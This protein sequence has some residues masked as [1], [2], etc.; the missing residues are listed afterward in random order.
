MLSEF[1]LIRKIRKKIGGEQIGDDC[2]AVNGRPGYY[3]L[4]TA[5]AFVEGVH[6]KFSTISATKAGQKCAG[7]ALSDIAAMGGIPLY[8]LVSLGLPFSFSE[9]KV[10]QFYDGL[11]S[12]CRRHQAKIVGGNVTRS[13]RFWADVTVV[14]EVK[15]GECKFRSGARPGDDIYVTGSLGGAALSGYRKIPMPRI[16]EGRSL[17]RM[18]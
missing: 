5:D 6:F 15:K 2:A 18:K 3:F 16:G 17:G 1:D 12:V 13:P 9:K 11:L 8:L 7:A 14:G 4:L 10:L